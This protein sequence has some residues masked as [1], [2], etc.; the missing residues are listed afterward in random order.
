MDTERASLFWDLANEMIAAGIAEEGTM[1]GSRCLRASGAFFAMID[2][3]TGH[4]IVKLP[5]HRVAD[6]VD[7][8]VGLAFAPAGRV[9]RE[10][11]AFPQQ[12]EGRWSALMAEGRAFV[13]G[14]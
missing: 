4:L 9:F 1:M 14:P 7:D 12:D 11:V 13:T 6:L 2:G 10:W 5:Q 3:S 8:G